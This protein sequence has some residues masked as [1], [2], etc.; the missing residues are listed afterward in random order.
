MSRR[1]HL[2]IGYPELPTNLVSCFTTKIGGVPFGFDP[3]QWPYCGNCNSPLRFVT[4][5]DLKKPLSLARSFDVA[6]LFVCDGYMS[7]PGND[8]CAT[9]YGYDGSTRIILASRPQADCVTRT[10]VE[11]WPERLIRFIPF[12]PYDD[13]FRAFGRKTFLEMMDEAEANALPGEDAVID[14]PEDQLPSRTML[15]GGDPAWMQSDETP[16]CPK[17]NG[18]MQLLAQVY[19]E[20]ATTK[21]SDQYWLPWGGG[22]GDAYLFICDRECDVA[23]NSFLWQCT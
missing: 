9:F 16:S 4:Q 7:R 2:L 3:S 22:S 14:L 20:V 19:S 15:I 21:W 17:C 23:G 18:P 6:Y 5:I 10:D 13:W 12:V 8:Q 1:E 11:P